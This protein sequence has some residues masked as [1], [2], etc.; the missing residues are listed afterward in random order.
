MIYHPYI[1]QKKVIKVLVFKFCQYLSFS[2]FFFTLRNF[3]AIV[4]RHFLVCNLI[5]YHL[6]KKN[7]PN[8]ALLASDMSL[9]RLL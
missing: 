1:W 2:R 9:N 6:K 4:S 7:A 8:S 3:F 5:F